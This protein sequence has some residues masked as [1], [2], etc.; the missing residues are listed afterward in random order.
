MSCDALNRRVKCAVIGI[1]NVGA[2]IAYTYSR[3]GLMS[4]LVLI[5][6][7]KRRAEG[8]AMD[9]S[10]GLPFSSPM[11]IYAG[12]YA[13][14]ADAALIVIAAGVAQ[15]EGERRLSLLKRTRAVFHS[16][17]DQIVKVT[18]DAILLVVTNPVDILTYETIRLSGYPPARV[19]GSGTVLDS[20]RLKQLLSERFSID[21]RNIHALIIG[22]HGDS[23]LP[24][25]SGANVSG[26]NL[27]DYCRGMGHP[28]NA[29]ER[30]EMFRSVRDAAYRIIEAKG[31]TYY[32]IAAAVMRITECILRSENSILP[33]SCRLDG[34]YGLYDI[35]LGIPAVI[36]R[37]GVRE[38]LNIPLS[39]EELFL[40]HASAARVR[41]ESAQS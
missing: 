40:L 34:Q 4:D 8:E 16:V 22:E 33:V 12:E 36:G 25:W 1:G 15:R 23:E 26:L 2:S 31:A 10:H 35:V 17:V 30:E 39:E 6:L 19:I 20:A 5:D 13:D 37:D 11:R 38:V 18:K 28:F 41:A 14:I 3:S 24:V 9:L 32:A 7:D 21:A 27:D 29:T